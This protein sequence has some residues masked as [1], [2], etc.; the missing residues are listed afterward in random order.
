MLQAGKVADDGLPLTALDHTAH[1][2][3]QR[4]PEGFPVG[5]VY[6]QPAD[7]QNAERNA[8]NLAAV[9]DSCMLHGYTLQLQVHKIINLE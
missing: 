6:L 8:L 1:P 9:I 5:A 4:P 3:L 7:E 2:R